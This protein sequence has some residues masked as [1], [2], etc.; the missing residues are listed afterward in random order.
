MPV[1]DLDEPLANLTI[2]L[3]HIVLPQVWNR[4]EMRHEEELTSSIRELGQL[5]PLIVIQCDDRPD[6]VELVDGRRRLHVLNAL[7]YSE[8][9]IALISR[10][11]AGNA[12][13][14]SCVTNITNDDNTAYE[15]VQI[16]KTLI[17]TYH[18]T[19]EEIAAACGKTPG[20][21]SQYLTVLKAS[22]DLQTA[23][24]E[25]KIAITYFRLF[26]RLD[27]KEDKRIYDKLTK[28]VVDDNM[29]FAVLEERITE[30]LRDKHENKPQPKRGAA[31]HKRPAAEL[32]DYTTAEVRQSIKPLDIDPMV[33]LLTQ[34]NQELRNASSNALRKYQQGVL[35]GVELA[36]G[37]RQL[38]GS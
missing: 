31:A 37:L 12:F 33:E 17:D 8:A 15:K 3:D 23:L 16:F 24:K 21:I 18:K 27:P 7:G 35:D 9:K 29:P 36:C 25:N 26:A 20:Y 10:K 2:A 22:D 1:D 19:H 38:K 6:F 5:V 14:V 4:Q 34:L 28:A 32:L 13:L 30:Y 11:D